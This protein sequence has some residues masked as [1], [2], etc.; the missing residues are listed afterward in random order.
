[1]KIPFQLL[2]KSNVYG[3]LLSLVF[4]MMV[5][6]ILGSESAMFIESSDGAKYGGL[7]YSVFFAIF[8]WYMVELMALLGYPSKHVRMWRVIL[9]AGCLFVFTLTNPLFSFLTDQQKV[10]SFSLSHIL[11]LSME[12]YFASIILKDIFRS[13]TTNNDH[14]WGAIVVFFIGVTMFSEIYELIT[15]IQPGLLGEVYEIGWPNYIHCIMFSLNSVAGLDSVYPGAHL[16]I[17][18]IATLE[19]VIANLFL[20]VILGRLLSNP[21]KKTMG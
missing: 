16:L 20:V 15:L 1:M 14:I 18:K 11:I 8:Y 7:V 5:V 19:N 13:E 9:I 12:I 6:V 10:V 4:V 17:R 3:R 2:T 21:I